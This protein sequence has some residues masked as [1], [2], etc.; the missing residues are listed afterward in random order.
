ML[1][2]ENPLTLESEGVSQSVRDAAPSNKLGSN[3]SAEGDS[4]INSSKTTDCEEIGIFC[5]NFAE[6]FILKFAK[7]S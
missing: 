6:N 3:Y 7:L 1:L 5:R 2:D 4:R